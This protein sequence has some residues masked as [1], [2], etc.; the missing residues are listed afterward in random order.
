MQEALAFL[1]VIIEV[2]M[3]SNYLKQFNVLWLLLSFISVATVANPAKDASKPLY[4]WQ[5]KS[6]TSQVY[7][8]GSVHVGTKDMYPL[9]KPVMDA[10]NESKKVVLE[11]KLDEVSPDELLAKSGL[12]PKGVKLTDLLSKDT[13]ETLKLYLAKHKLPLDQ[14]QTFRPWAIMSFIDTIEYAKLG[15]QYELGVEKYFENLMH[16]QKKDMIGLETAQEQIDAI[17]GGN[18][19][20]RKIESCNCTVQEYQDLL[21][22]ETLNSTKKS[23]VMV[24]QLFKFWNNGQAD[25]LYDLC[26]KDILT[27][28]KIGQT[29]VDALFT[30]RNIKMADGIAELLKTQEK[31]FVLVGAGHIGGKQGI[32]QLLKD[33]GLT[34]EQV[35]H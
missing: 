25:K 16:S 32:V 31:Y 5:V 4:L 35:R 19:L 11:V 27:N 18:D 30:K 28:E 24:S 9:A 29:V 12:N 6:P 14:L 34:V 13:T 10:F 7:I 23:E 20:S 17:S 21:L 8:F 15:F 22:R 33:K 3:K 2:V 26:A 1:S